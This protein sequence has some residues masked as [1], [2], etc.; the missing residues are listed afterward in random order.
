MLTLLV[1]LGLGTYCMVTLDPQI[2]RHP[3]L[4][5][6][7]RSVPGEHLQDYLS[8]LQGRRPVLCLIFPHSI[9]QLLALLQ[10]VSLVVICRLIV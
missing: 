7:L 9:F 8:T 1:A 2:L 4:S 3:A 6:P 5:S 10:E